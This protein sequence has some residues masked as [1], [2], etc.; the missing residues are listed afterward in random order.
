M[1]FLYFFP[2]PDKS[3]NNEQSRKI[4]STKKCF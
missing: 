2:D 1:I 3:T 4:F